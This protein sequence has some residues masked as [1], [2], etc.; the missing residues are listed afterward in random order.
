LE[1]AIDQ[2]LLK[3]SAWRGVKAGF[4]SVTDASVRRARLMP[5]A[6][7]KQ[8]K[9]LPLQGICDDAPVDPL[10]AHLMGHFIEMR[11]NQENPMESRPTQSRGVAI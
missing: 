11:A 8:A 3:S 1:I 2:R 7:K 10:G 9:R 5:A 4:F 6:V